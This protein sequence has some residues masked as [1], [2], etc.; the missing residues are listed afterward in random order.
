VANK[1]YW[2]GDLL[3][4]GSFQRDLAIGQIEPGLQP[5]AEEVASGFSLWLKTKRCSAISAFG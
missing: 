3:Y 2:V 4:I 1:G 5:L